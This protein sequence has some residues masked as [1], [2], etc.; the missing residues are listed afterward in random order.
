MHSLRRIST[1]VVA[2]ALLF[3]ACGDDGDGGEASS[4]STTGGN[5]PT[6][7]SSASSSTPGAPAGE[8][9]PDGTGG[10]LTIGTINPPRT[11]DPMIAPGTGTV[12]GNEILALY[13]TL[14]RYDPE[15]GSYEPWLAASIT[16]NASFTEWTVELR[17][18]VRFG[19]GDPL[20]A[21]AV[22][23]SFE[24]FQGEAN[25]TPNGALAR[26]VSS[27]EAKDERTVVFTTDEPWPGFPFILAN[28][29]G[30][31]V[32]TAVASA[33]G[34]S[35]G[36]DATGAGAGPFELVRYAPGEE[37]VLAAKPDYWG[38]EVCVAELRFVSIPG[39]RATYEALTNE[40][41]DV[42]MVRDPVVSAEAADDDVERLTTM[43]HLGGLVLFN[44]GARG[45]EHPTSDQRVREAAALAIDLDA[46]NQRAYGGAA[47]TTS[48]IVH[49]DGLLA[50]GVD[51]PA[52]DPGR[53]RAL[54]A[55]VKT[56]TGW[57]GSVRLLCPPS[58]PE[59]PIFLEGSLRA[60]GFDVVVEQIELSAFLPK[61]FSSDF[62]VACTGYNLLDAG[63]WETLGPVMSADSAANYGGF[64]DDAW[65]EA[66]NALR[67][68]S[69]LDQ[70]REA[71]GQLQRI[72]N[73]K[74]P[75]AVTHSAE[76]DILV[77]PRVRGVVQSANGLAF[78]DRAYV[79]RG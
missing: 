61:F 51:G 63:P 75:G 30:M 18:D 12:G 59:L 40:E 8:R 48:A 35:F 37:L 39:A 36:I 60:V 34:D 1:F 52:H 22:V 19:N 79:Q 69:T 7:T 6:T 2:G 42:A 77:G 57:D 27:V 24:R 72:W 3:A 45:G 49:P 55:E 47:L 46:L 62:D 5:A 56:E 68:A 71:I 73:E 15:T 13:D 29:G 44:A 43:V 65:T 31:I 33:K 76:L 41:L 74:V 54:V 16:P 50:S 23:A 17:P 53:A 78:F 21:A 67:L 10:R 32:N 58:A 28:S 66:M 70:Q 26:N 20:D 11:L 25:A 64:V 9:C 4:P 38:G 14:L